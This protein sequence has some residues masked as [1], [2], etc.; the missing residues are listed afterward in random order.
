MFKAAQTTLSGKFLLYFLPVA[1]L[2]LI[3][4]IFFLF[5]F[6]KDSI[7]KEVRESLGALAVRHANQI[8]NYI[9]ERQDSVKTLAQMP[10]I[11]DAIVR[12]QRE[13]EASASYSY[14]SNPANEI[15]RNFLL[16]Y[17]DTYGYEDLFFISRKGNVLF[18]IKNKEKAGTNLN[19]GPLKDTQLAKV[20]LSA[21]TLLE[22]KISEFDYYPP[23]KGYAGFISAPIFSKDQFF[24]VVALQMNLDK[25]H[26][27]VNDYTG[28]G[29]T[30]E[31]VVAAKVATDILFMAPL[32]LKPDVA[33]NKN[34]SSE[35]SGWLPIQQAVEKINGSGFE[36]DYRGKGVF[37]SWRY[38]P[39]IRWGM[40]IK[41]DTS[42]AFSKIIQLKKISIIFGIV[43][44]LLIVGVVLILAKKVT[45]PIRNLI[46]VIQKIS[47]GD[48]SQ[49][50]TV[51][52]E[53][54]IGQLAQSFN[55][56]VV[57]LNTNYLELKNTNLE[58]VQ[59]NRDIVKININL[60]EANSELQ[61]MH[62][63]LNTKLAELRQS[64]QDLENFATIASH[65]L[66]APVRKIINFAEL[67]DKEGNGIGE[68]DRV[69]LEKIIKSGKRMRMLMDDIL[70]YSRL[71]RHSMPF[72][73]MNLNDVMDEVLRTLSE[74]IK[75]TGGQIDLEDFPVIE[76]N[77]TQMTQLFQ[78]L[79]SNSLKYKNPSKAPVIK[80]SSKFYGDGFVEIVFED[81]GAGFNEKYA[82]LIFQPF[83]RLEPKIEG[84]GMGLAICKKVV[85]CHGGEISVTSKILQGSTF[86]IKLPERH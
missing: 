49:K 42:E 9:K 12:M 43:C 62:S 65:D 21:F 84:T 46:D 64:N 45:H 31:T 75:E 11:I 72:E 26:K 29:K 8:E 20:F 34:I 33:F 68:R 5:S 4:V 28:L 52:K 82:H 6:A 25:L 27:I 85:V 50:I 37:A 81:N 32:R 70:N 77:R 57:I 61:K 40:V 10:N 74:Q 51:N 19:T 3:V 48:L 73:R 76:A 79:I 7:E 58:L 23:S 69:L 39:G 2:P 14:S 83:E 1:L 55:K 38:L 24:G 86:T 63:L 44:L 15:L 59:R 54:E 22:T 56:M 16:S 60:N 41:M 47:K 30:G 53:H 17:K 36:K 18:S 71:A 13:F 35:I 78:N 67:M 66:M 80:I